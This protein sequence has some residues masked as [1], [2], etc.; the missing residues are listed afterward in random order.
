MLGNGATFTLN[1]GSVGTIISLDPPEETIGEVNDDSLGTTDFHEFVA[2]KVADTSPLTGVAV[3]NGGTLP[4]LGTQLT[5]TITY[6][7]GTG[8]TTGA[9]FAGTGF[10]TR[11]KIGELA[12]DSRV[13]LE[14]SFRFD[15][16]TGP[17]YTAGS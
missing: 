6:P 14:F 16:K 12:L 5:G 1:T 2:A 3:F 4:S 13:V 17:A 15:G 7:L 10:F 11:R 8:Q 9:T